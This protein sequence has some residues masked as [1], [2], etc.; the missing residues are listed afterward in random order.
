MLSMSLH[1]VTKPLSPTQSIQTVYKL[2]LYSKP[3][4]SNTRPAWRVYA[5][6][7]VIKI[8]LITDKTTVLWGSWVLFGSIVAR[9]DIFAY[10][11]GPQALLSSKCGPRI[12]SSLRPLL[13]ADDW[14]MLLVFSLKTLL[15]IP[16][17]WFKTFCR[18]ESWSQPDQNLFF[19]HIF[20]LSC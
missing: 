6:R 8:P 9:G 18:I 2:M 15:K 14:K 1:L 5:A 16:E 4:V 7:V 11:C 3:G 10:L 12:H 20:Q 17:Y 13:K 19:L